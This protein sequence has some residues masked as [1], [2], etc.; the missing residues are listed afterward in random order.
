MNIAQQTTDK[1]KEKGWLKSASDAY[2]YESFWF[3][4]KNKCEQT[5]I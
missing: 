1:F 3:W 2:C 4:K 5:L